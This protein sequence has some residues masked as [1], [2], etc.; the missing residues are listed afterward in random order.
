MADYCVFSFKNGVGQYLCTT[1]RT[2][3]AF[4]NFPMCKAWGIVRY[5]VCRSCDERTFH[6]FISRHCE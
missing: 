3:C 5:S 1:C 6:H 4:Q 2:H